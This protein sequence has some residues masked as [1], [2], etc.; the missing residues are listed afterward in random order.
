MAITQPLLAALW[1]TQ[2]RSARHLGGDEVGYKVR[3]DSVAQRATKLTFMT[4]G[5]AENSG[6]VTVSNKTI[7]LDEAHGDL[8]TPMLFG[9]VKQAVELRKNK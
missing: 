4:D 1:A 7:V 9:L 2:S 5:K 3:F 8:W 6:D